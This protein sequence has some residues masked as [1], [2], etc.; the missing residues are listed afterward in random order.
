MWSGRAAAKQLFTRCITW[1]CSRQREWNW[2]WIHCFVSEILKVQLVGR[3]NFESHSQLVKHWPFRMAA[4]PN[5]Y[6]FKFQNFVNP[7]NLARPSSYGRQRHQHD[8]FQLKHVWIEVTVTLG[9]K[10]NLG[11]FHLA[12]NSI[13]TSAFEN[14]IKRFQVI[15]Y[16][17]QWRG[18]LRYCQIQPGMTMSWN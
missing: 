2:E 11:I 1:N 18:S 10:F 4:D 8:L 12:S 15:S 6:A 14:C 5:N 16:S 17:L 3:L 7:V 9:T 13:P